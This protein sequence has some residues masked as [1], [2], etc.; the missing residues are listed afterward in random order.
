MIHKK[1]SG[2]YRISALVALLGTAILL[3]SGLA[4]AAIE[5]DIRA[6]L[7]APGQVCVMGE[8]CAAG[9]AVAG[10][11]SGEPK[12]PEEV[13]QTYCFA[14]HGT[15][16]NESPVLGVASDWEDRVAKGVD[17]LYANAINGFNN[18]LMPARGLCMDCSDEDIEA[19]VDYMLDALD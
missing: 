4:R 14:C 8:D 15:G 16:A 3:V 7:Q 19:T 2:Q 17:E 5:D 11:D 18:G 6:R 13:Y 12:D 9:M 1:A 10:G